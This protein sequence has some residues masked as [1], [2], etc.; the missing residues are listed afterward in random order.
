MRAWT[1]RGQRDGRG[2]EG[3]GSGAHIQTQHTHTEINSKRTLKWRG[4]GGELPPCK[5]GLILQAKWCHFWLVLDFVFTAKWWWQMCIKR[6][7]WT[8]GCGAETRTG[9]ERES[10]HGK[11]YWM[12]LCTVSEE[13]E[14]RE[15]NKE[16]IL[17]Q[18]NRKS[19][20]T[21][22]GLEPGTFERTML[23]TSPADKS[24]EL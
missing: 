13:E 10:L 11:V 14:E 20:C 9:N 5:T 21:R 16:N 23:S 7:K 24:D 1:R 8:E 2:G 15:E 6:W 18:T 12:E 3:K 17:R 22:A 19:T 4:D